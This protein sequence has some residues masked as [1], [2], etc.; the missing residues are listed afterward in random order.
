MKSEHI[1]IGIRKLAETSLWNASGDCADIVVHRLR[2]SPQNAK[3]IIRLIMR[4]GPN[5]STDIKRAR[6]IMGKN[7]FGVEEAIK[8]FN[9]KL[10]TNELAY[11]TKV[12]W[13]KDVLT[14]CKDTH[15][16][17]AV[18]PLSICGVRKKH[19]NLFDDIFWYKDETFANRRGKTEWRLISK[20]PLVPDTRGEIRKANKLLAIDEY[21]PN[22][23]TM[24]YATIGHFL[25]TGEKLFE[26][27]LC[28]RCFDK[29]L[30]DKKETRNSPVI[31]F[32]ED[33]LRIENV[34][35]DLVVVAATD[36]LAI[37]LKT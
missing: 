9:P 1:N 32:E 12:P 15:L 7:F 24:V 8:V 34:P 28:V 29:L 6:E 5:R 25:S 11:L 26:K 27:P 33:M 18:F 4:S 10:H 16:L 37:A 31:F 22:A 19:K 20:I 35:H 36:S 17:V 3:N 14:F 2:Q 21:I 13:N 23:Q 30:D